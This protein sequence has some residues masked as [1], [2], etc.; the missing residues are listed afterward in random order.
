[1]KNTKGFTL[2]ELLITMVL[3]IIVIAI[4]GSA[5]NIIVKT[6]SR[7]TSSE[8][9]NIKGV[10]GLEILRH[11]LQQAGF[12]LFD[13]IKDYNPAIAYY[14]EA[15]VSPANWLNDNTPASLH[16]PRAFV[17]I[18]NIGGAS[19][20]ASETGTTYNVLPN[21]DYLGIKATNVGRSKAA[22]KWTYIKYSSFNNNPQDKAP[23]IWPSAAD[24]LKNTEIAIVIKRS[25]SITGQVSNELITP[26]GSPQTYWIDNPTAQI[27]TTSVNYPA[28]GQVNFIYG[29]D[30]AAPLGMPFNRTDYF[31]AHPSKTDQFPTVCAPNTGILYRTTVYQDGGKLNYTPLLDCVA[32]MQV[33]FGWD[34]LLNGEITESGATDLLT[35]PAIAKIMTNAAEIRN[36]LKYVKVY[37]MAQDGRRDSNYSNTNTLGPA[38]NTYSV[39][40][41]EPGPTPSSNVNITKAYTADQLST[42]D[43]LHYRWKVY[44]IVVRPKNLT[45]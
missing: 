34:L 8:E 29:V 32:D 2:I 18:N 38:N 35:P 4:T 42:Q 22:Q 6:T 24:N 36:K 10:V 39:V 9:S 1:M 31:V 45:N 13:S 23:Y 5:F 28:K 11:D 27:S 33:V 44:R 12:G 26:F 20:S 41:G 19:D 43:W 7:V 25:F 16:I 37:I 30:D 21:T 17:S 15:T 3:V 14:Q 40:V